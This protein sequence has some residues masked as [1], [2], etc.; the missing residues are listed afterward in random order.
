[1]TRLLVDDGLYSGQQ[2][3]ELEDDDTKISLVAFKVVA[4]L[5]HCTREWYSSH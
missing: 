3:V 2:L 4:Q 5:M 1:M